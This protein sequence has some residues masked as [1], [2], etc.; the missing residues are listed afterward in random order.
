MQDRTERTFVPSLA[1]KRRIKESGEHI[2]L[3]LASQDD[4]FDIL[5]GRGWLGRRV[6]SVRGR[7]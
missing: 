5:D 4:F 2:K 7:L 6:S 3:N 1:T